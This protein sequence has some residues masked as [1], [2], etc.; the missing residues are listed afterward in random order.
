MKKVEKF[1]QLMA[2][3]GI[4]LTPDEA[5]VAYRMA[6]KVRKRTRKLA[7]KDLWQLELGLS[8]EEKKYLEILYHARG[9]L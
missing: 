5:A 7:Q 9:T 8:E 6:I 3:K 1:R 2:E 4:E